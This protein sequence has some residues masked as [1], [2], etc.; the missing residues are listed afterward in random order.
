MSS[1]DLDLCYLAATEAIKAFKA[2]KLS[3]VELLDA[4]ISRIVNVGSKINAITYDYFDRARDQAKVAEQK[5]AKGQRLRALEGIPTAIKDWHP[6]KGEITTYGSRTREHFRPDNTAPT[7]ERLLDAGAIMHIRTTTPEFGHSPLTH[8]PL[9]GVT[10]NPWNLEYSSGGSSGGAGATLASG[11]T[12]IADGT[13]GGGS[14]R[15]PASATGVFGYKPPFGRNPIDRE[16]PGELLLHYGGLA[17]CVSDLALMQNVTSGAHP[18]D[19]HS[20]REKI[21]I[22]SAFADIRGWKIALSMNLGYFEVDNEVQKNTRKMVEHF[23]S[24]GATVEE[25][26]LGWTIATEEAW[27]T[28]WEG[29]LYAGEG[30]LLPERADELDPFVVT[31]LEKGRTRTLAEFYGVKKVIAQMYATLAPILDSYN[32]L[33]TPTLALPSVKAD[34]RNDDPLTINGKTVPSYNGWNMNYPF[35]LVG[36]CPVMT[37]PSGFSRETGVPTGLQIVGRTYDDLSVFQAASALEAV[38]KPW[39][40]K[41]PKL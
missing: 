38:T 28:R 25:V 26:D 11:M 13:D 22:P 33:I 16:H 37:V 5:Y 4:Q 31:L 27:L 32:I 8:S 39:A 9:W 41:R 14:V 36:Q 34:R 23:T 12:A 6:V 21:F 29:I 20:L 17:R 2:K 30:H 15:I 24:L 40:S 18:A 3:P 10:R 35:N 1:P 7:V 19:L